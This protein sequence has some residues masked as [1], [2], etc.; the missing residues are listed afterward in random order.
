MLSSSP[1]ANLV[2]FQGPHSWTRYFSHLHFGRVDHI[3][4]SIV[5]SIEGAPHHLLL[6]WLSYFS[7]RFKA[8]VAFV[9]ICVF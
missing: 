7:Q 2:P 6:L 5:P 9:A 1:H 8:F 4:L 3:I